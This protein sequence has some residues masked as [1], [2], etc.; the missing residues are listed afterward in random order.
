MKHLLQFSLFSLFLLSIAINSTA[1]SYLLQDFESITNPKGEFFDTNTNFAAIDLVTNPSKSGINL[2]DKTAGVKVGTGSGIIKINFQDGITPQTI[3]PSDPTGQNSLYYDRLRFKYYKGSNADRYVELEPNG[4]PTSP[5]TLTPANGSDW[6]YIEF[7]LT[8]KMYNNFQIRV[9]RNADG[10]GSAGALTSGQYIYVDDF[11]L[12][13]YETG[14][15]TAIK[16]QT[17]NIDFQFTQTDNK[18]YNLISFIDTPSDVKIDLISIDGRSTRLFN[19]KTSGYFTLPV[20]VQNKGIYFIRM[21]A[22]NRNTKT[23]KFINH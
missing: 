2:S 6:I 5:K 14:P 8:N 10:S 4:S 15:T 20:Q 21:T 23:L 17:Q 3:Y 1:G 7:V 13:N 19:Q 9:N 16:I 18:S 11:E 22:D 12:Y